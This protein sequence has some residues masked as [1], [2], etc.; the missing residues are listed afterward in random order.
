[1]AGT[2]QVSHKAIGA[3]VRRRPY[4][5]E[6]DGEPVGSVDMNA[7]FETAVAAGAHT[8]RVR[9]G[10]KSSRAHAFEIADGQ[11]VA[12]RATGKRF[13]P[14]FLLSF[15]FPDLALVLVRR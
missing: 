8:V 9:E 1:M 11:T 6:L 12:F 14:L 3:E 13:L 7:T 5:V 2:L 10:R 15:F 4:A